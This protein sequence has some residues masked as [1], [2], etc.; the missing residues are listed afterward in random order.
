MT[1]RLVWGVCLPLLFGLAPAS[2]QP[3]KVFVNS[4]VLAIG[5]RPVLLDLKSQRIISHGENFE[6][7]LSPRPEAE[8]RKVSEFRYVLFRDLE[9]GRVRYE[10]EI[11]RASCRE[12][13]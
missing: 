4:A 5:E 3:A 1:T 13:V 9:K 2:A 12:R 10:W 11:G 7:D 6:P 8:P